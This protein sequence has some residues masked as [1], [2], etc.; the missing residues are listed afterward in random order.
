MDSHQ[1][2]QD[3]RSSLAFSFERKTSLCA[4]FLSLIPV[5]GASI[6]FLGSI[7][8]QSTICASDDVAA[9]LDELQFDLGEGPSWEALSSG[10][11]ALHS[12]V[13]SESDPIW[14]E[15][16]SAIQGADVG[17][18]YAFPLLVGSLQVGAVD[19]YSNDTGQLTHR[20]VAD[21]TALAKIAT[22]QVLRRVLAR[23]PLD[24]DDF[25]SGP[26]FSRREIHQATGMV[27]AQLDV[28]ADDATLL[29]RAH[30][31]SRDRSVREIASDIVER[32]LS[33]AADHSSNP[34]APAQ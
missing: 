31:F 12:H 24:V 6:S 8:A 15:F 23:N 17:A 1:R 26:V 19:L 22:W 3:A 34:A 2:L 21:A 18:I 32:R 13:Q 29:L 33:F 25:Q 20:Q 14:P 9:H 7:S 11:P 30:A 10:Q 5:S 28:T 16:A 4:P 27:I